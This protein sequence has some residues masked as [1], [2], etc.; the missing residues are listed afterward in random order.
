MKARLSVS[1]FSL[2]NTKVLCI[3]FVGRAGKAHVLYKFSIIRD[4][5]VIS[6]MYGK[7]EF[8]IINVRCPTFIFLWLRQIYIERRSMGYL[9]K[10]FQIDFSWYFSER[11]F[12]VARHTFP[13][14][15]TI[16]IHMWMSWI[17]ECTYANG[18]HVKKSLPRR[19]AIWF[20]SMES[21]SYWLSPIFLWRCEDNFMLCS[22]QHY[23]CISVRDMTLN[24]GKKS[25]IFEWW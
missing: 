25:M 12:Y 1:L 7:Q 24:V 17:D 20:L 6:Q 15:K 4:D 18:M 21:I 10:N 11:D 5:C 14:L 22:V 9:W 8:L 23:F 2:M 13:Y 19:R 16:S 3:V